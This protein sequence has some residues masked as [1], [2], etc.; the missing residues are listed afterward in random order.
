MII[1]FNKNQL[2]QYIY[3]STSEV[4]KK[5]HAKALFDIVV[6]RQRFSKHLRGKKPLIIK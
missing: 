2:W 5:Y 4:K 6:S 1:Y 3:F